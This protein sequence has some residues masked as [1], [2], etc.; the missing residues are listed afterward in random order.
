MSAACQS[1]CQSLLSRQNIGILHPVFS[2]H[3]HERWGAR[4]WISC[5]IAHLPSHCSSYESLRNSLT[6]QCL[7][8]STAILY[9]N[10]FSPASKIM[11]KNKDGGS[12]KHLF[13]MPCLS[14]LKPSFRF[15]RKC[16]SHCK[17]SLNNAKSIP[18]PS[19]T[20][21]STSHLKKCI[22]SWPFCSSFNLHKYHNSSF[23]PYVLPDGFMPTS[24]LCATLSPLILI[25][26]TFNV[27]F[28]DLPRISCH[29]C[30]HKKQGSG[31]C[32]VEQAAL[33]DLLTVR[34][35]HAKAVEPVPCH[36]DARKCHSQLIVFE[37]DSRSRHKSE[38]NRCLA[39]RQKSC[40]VRTRKLL[41]V[42]S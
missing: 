42:L 7:H 23:F 41:K 24:F 4:V 29:Y 17:N 2:E 30:M 1:E 36:Q 8:I 20:V 22:P 3:C 6:L 39:G 14:V 16:S 15:N 37:I 31:R 13:V 40:L 38:W 11:I 27:A 32:R 21:E 34:H 26:I 5:G 28:G 19:T 33:P 10:E 9:D 12:V 18:H 25:Y 35:G